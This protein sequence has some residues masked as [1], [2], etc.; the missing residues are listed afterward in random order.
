MIYDMWK[1]TSINCPILKRKCVVVNKDRNDTMLP[2]TREQ[3]RRCLEKFNKTN[4][5]TQ[6]LVILYKEIVLNETPTQTAPIIKQYHKMEMCI[7]V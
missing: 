7:V 6:N 5:P 4:S 1:L 3:Q 2:T